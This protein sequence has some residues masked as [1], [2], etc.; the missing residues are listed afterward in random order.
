MTN[1]VKPIKCRRC[2]GEGARDW[3]PNFGQCFRCGGA[4]VV[5][6]DKATLAAAKA[7]RADLETAH[8]LIGDE[9]NRRKVAGKAAGLG[10]FAYFEAANRVRLGFIQLE[11]DDP[12]RFRKA[13]ASVVAG[14]PRVFDAL[15]DYAHS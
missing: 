9:V 4:G 12:E 10:F 1:L 13:V 6:G 3:R 7:F 11:T 15:A 14:H 2:Q 8:R 5:E